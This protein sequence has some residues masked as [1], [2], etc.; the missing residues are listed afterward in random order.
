MIFFPLLSSIILLPLLG[1]IIAFFIK[2]EEQEV[3]KNIR[4]L[5]LWISITEL[6]LVIFTVIQFDA[7]TEG[8]QFIEKKVLLSI[9]YPKDPKL[10]LL[11]DATLL[12]S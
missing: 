12:N 4:D 3:S 6:V 10:W 1:A 8:F 5:A 2:G 11:N 9:M 7:N